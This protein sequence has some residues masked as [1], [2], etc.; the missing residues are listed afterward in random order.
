MSFKN[1]LEFALLFLLWILI[2]T[3]PYDVE[4][5]NQLPE[6][7]SKYSINFKTWPNEFLNLNNNQSTG[8]GVKI[9]ILDT[10]IKFKNIANLRG[11][12]DFLSDHNQNKTSVKSTHADQIV[13]IISSIAPDAEIYLI[14]IVDEDGQL[15]EHNLKNALNWIQENQVDIVNMSFG[16]N[17]AMSATI[18]PIL[19]QL[20]KQNT[21]L[22][23]S[24]GNEGKSRVLYPASSQYTISVGANDFLGQ[25]W[26][27]SNYGK[28]LDFTMPG[29]KII[30]KYRNI[31]VDGTSFSAAYMSGFIARLKESNPNISNNEMYVKLV[32]MTDT[33]K[34]NETNGYGTPTFH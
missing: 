19:E 8:Q 11:E 5:T 32:E 1:S 10:A 27:Q 12:Y 23:A 17:S 9:A 16:F 21:I 14:V 2:S 31:F 33:H 20:Y 25:T 15:K 24:S 28:E 6:S 30:D 7:N 18:E 29:V 22:V 34:W 26:F 13:S 3:I 4:K